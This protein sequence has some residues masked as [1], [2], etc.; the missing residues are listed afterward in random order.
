MKEK[1]SQLFI[2]NKVENIHGQ[3][4]VIRILDNAQIRLTAHLSIGEEWTSLQDFR[5]GGIDFN[6]VFTHGDIYIHSEVIMCRSKNIMSEPKI[7]GA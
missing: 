4:T 6:I 7:Y 3:D 1:H 5:N 2:L